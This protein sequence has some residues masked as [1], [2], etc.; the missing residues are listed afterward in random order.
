[1]ARP[2]IIED[3]KT[4]VTNLK[5]LRTR[6][7]NLAFRDQLG[8]SESR[9]AKVKEALVEKGKIAKGRGRGG[10]IG[11]AASDFSWE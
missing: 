6:V 10:S 1:M 3:E 7:G 4:F 9:Y 2:S 11:I 5:K 8:W